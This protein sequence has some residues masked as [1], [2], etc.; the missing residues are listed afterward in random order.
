VTENPAQPVRHLPLLLRDERVESLE[1]WNRTGTDYPRDQTLI[2][3]FGVQV[4]RAPDAVAL[5]AGEQQ[6][7]YRQLDQRAN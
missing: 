6:L 4:A 1:D 2:D 3:L 5:S 7:T